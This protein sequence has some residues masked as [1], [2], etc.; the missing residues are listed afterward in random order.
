MRWHSIGGCLGQL[1]RAEGEQR[2]MEWIANDTKPAV[3]LW[4]GPNKA[5]QPR[6]PLSCYHS[7]HRC[8]L[9]LQWICIRRVMRISTGGISHLTSQCYS[10]SLSVK[11]SKLLS[12]SL[13]CVNWSGFYELAFWTVAASNA[14]LLYVLPLLVQHFHSDGY[15]CIA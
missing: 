3:Y 10:V 7:A 1:G 13:L 2:R 9:I 11:Q 5:K 15:I 12:P 8:H 14:Q 4:N 6:N